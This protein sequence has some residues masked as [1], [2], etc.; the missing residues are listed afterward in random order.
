MAEE[1]VLELGAATV[2]HAPATCEV[3]TNA[4]GQVKLCTSAA[5]VFTLQ[6]AS[7]KNIEVKVLDVPPPLEL[8]G[9]WELHFP[10]GWG[11]PARVSLPALISWSRDR[12]TRYF[13]NRSS[14]EFEVE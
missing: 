8:T 13:G 9:P 1:E 3:V 6:T 10:P 14:C 12:L 5:G 7:D 11:A 4:A 2:A